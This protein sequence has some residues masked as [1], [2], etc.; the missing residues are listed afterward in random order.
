[1]IGSLE[2]PVKLIAVLLLAACG[3]ST[4]VTQAPAAP[5]APAAE[6]P[7][8][9]PAAE[10]PQA[11]SGVA[12]AA[13]PAGLPDLAA[14]LAHGQCANGPGAEGADSY[15]V[16]EFTINGT[17]VTGTERWFVFANPKLQASK[18]WGVGESCVLEWK[19]TG[20]TS[21]AGNCSGC[22]MGI[23]FHA[24]PNLSSNCPKE[25]VQGR[26]DPHGSGKKVGGEGVAFDQQYGIQKNADGTA[27]FY[28]AKSGKRLAQGYAKGNGL[29]Y[30]TDH[31]CKWF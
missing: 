1:M 4:P 12:N 2:V 30:V 18:H 23:K 11:E 31:A 21:D 17:T 24:E 6:Q 20:S 27:V 25:L 29:A 22:S 28:F 10:Q 7:Q 15:F 16:G 9:A 3:G 13:P 14:N 19:V 26:D 8:A 5:A